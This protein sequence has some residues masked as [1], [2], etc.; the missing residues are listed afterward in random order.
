MQV[1][2]L[3]GLELEGAYFPSKKSAAAV[4]GRDVKRTGRPPSDSN[5]E[6]RSNADPLAKLRR[7]R[8]TALASLLEGKAS[9]RRIL[10]GRWALPNV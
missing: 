9:H 5:R 1:D 10:L 3:G 2:R 7:F 6:G 4:A 8:P